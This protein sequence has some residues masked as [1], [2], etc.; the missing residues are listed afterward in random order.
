MRPFGAYF[1]SKYS[2]DKIC[3]GRDK[4]CRN[5]SDYFWGKGQEKDISVSKIFSGIFMN[6]CSESMGRTSDAPNQG[7]NSG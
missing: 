7:F 5:K 6:R 2:I 4:N 1:F 3:E